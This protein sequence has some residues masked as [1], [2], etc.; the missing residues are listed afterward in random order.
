MGTLGNLGHFWVLWALWALL[1]TLGAKGTFGHSGYSE[2]LRV[3]KSVQSSE[4]FD[5]FMRKLDVVHKDVGGCTQGSWRLSD[6]MRIAASIAQI[7]NHE[8]LTQSV[9]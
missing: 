3:H 8:S 6:Q 1:G 5:G 7:D 9:T 4:Q 2:V